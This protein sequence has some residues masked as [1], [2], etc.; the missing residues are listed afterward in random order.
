VTDIVCVSHQ[1]PVELSGNVVI[2]QGGGYCG[3]EEFTTRVLTRDQAMGLLLL[4]R[5]LKILAAGS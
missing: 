2:V 5:G 1:K 4:D 3:S